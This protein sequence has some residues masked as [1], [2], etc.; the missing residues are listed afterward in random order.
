MLR[1]QAEVVSADGTRCDVLTNA[2]AWECEWSK[3]WK[4]AIGQTLSYAVHHN[5]G[6]GIILM[7]RNKASDKLY[8]NRCLVVCV[9]V[10]IPIAVINT[11]NQSKLEEQ[12]YEIRRLSK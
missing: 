10:K 7:T 3:K 1:A 12:M 9:Q 2:I 4:E 8:Y 5:R 6:P 11:V